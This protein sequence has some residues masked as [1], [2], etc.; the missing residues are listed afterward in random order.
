[1]KNVTTDKK[2]IDWML[3]LVPFLSIMA[4]AGYMFLFPL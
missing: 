4:L 3:T 1:M 2:R